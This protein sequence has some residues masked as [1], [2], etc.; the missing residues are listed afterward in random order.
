MLIY[1]QTIGED[2]VIEDFRV[3]ALHALAIPFRFSVWLVAARA[4]NFPFKA[5]FILAIA[6]EFFS[7]H[8]AAPF[9]R[10]PYSV[11]KVKRM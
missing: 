5:L 7:S 9:C 10:P 3:P 8:I 11:F 2:R 4:V 6:L 1:L